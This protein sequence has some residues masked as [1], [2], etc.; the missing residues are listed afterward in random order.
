[1]LHTFQYLAKTVCKTTIP[2]QS[3]K[4]KFW[5]KICLFNLENKKKAESWQ[6]RI[7]RLIESIVKRLHS[8]KPHMVPHN[9]NYNNIPHNAFKKFHCNKKKTWKCPSLV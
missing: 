9:H 7:S 6:L 3:L 4:K 1:M 8:R 5:L 2:D